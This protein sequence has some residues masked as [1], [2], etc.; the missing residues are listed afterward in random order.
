[1]TQ[2]ITCVI[3]KCDITQYVR[4]TSVLVSLFIN[5]YELL[6]SFRMHNV[7]ILFYSRD[8]S[9]NGPHANWSIYYSMFMILIIILSYACI[10]K[11]CKIFKSM[12][13]T[14]VKNFVERGI[15]IC[16][17]III[18]VVFKKCIQINLFKR[19]VLG[20]IK[21]KNGSFL[22][23]FQNEFVYSYEFLLAFII[24]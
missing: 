1:M 17:N 13:F 19:I 8:V 14:F 16:K 4:Q 21:S 9:M 22:I 15:Y 11:K 5:Q 12:Y 10:V 6:L 23:L 18:L 24:C 20:F 2:A 7:C 3:T